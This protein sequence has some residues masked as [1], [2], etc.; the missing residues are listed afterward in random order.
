MEVTFKIYSKIPSVITGHFENET[1]T[2]KNM[3]KNRIHNILMKQGKK[4]YGHRFHSY[5]VKP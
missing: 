4:K 1:V 5:T 2:V 3:G